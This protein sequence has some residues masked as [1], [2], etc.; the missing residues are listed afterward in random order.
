MLELTSGCMPPVA[1][2][3]QNGPSGGNAAVAVG[4]RQT[5]NSL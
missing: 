4:G 5:T 2:A 1:D 3:E